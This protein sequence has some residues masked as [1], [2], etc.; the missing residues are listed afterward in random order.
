MTRI[1]FTNITQAKQQLKLMFSKPII[2]TQ[3]VQFKPN[4]MKLSNI[5]PSFRKNKASQIKLVRLSLPFY[6]QTTIF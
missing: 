4:P 6:C 1:K 5:N 3:K 2:K